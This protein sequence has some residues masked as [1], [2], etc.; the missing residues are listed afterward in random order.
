MK[1]GRIGKLRS[2]LL[3]LVIL[4]IMAVSATA[5]VFAAESDF[6]EEESISVSVISDVHYYPY[7]FTG[8]QAQVYQDYLNQ[9]P[10]LLAESSFILDRA[11]EMAAAERPDYLLIPGDLTKDG[12]KQ[13]H[14]ELSARLKRFEKETG[15]EV[16]VING[17]HDINNSDAVTFENDIYESAETVTPAEFRAFYDGLGYGHADA[18]YYIPAEGKAAGGLSYTVPLNGGY[19]LLALDTGIYSSDVNPDGIDEHITGGG[20]APDALLWA[21]EVL[22][23]AKENNETVIA[24]RP[25][26]RREN[27]FRNCRLV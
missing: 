22:E 8:S 25:C 24:L 13:G 5:V 18:E 23:E 15:V 9:D 12:E 20:L 16:Y 19:R 27:L 26:D 17:N 6:I 1:K 4:C 21:T 11:L 3:S 7:K 14:A 10:K 2:I